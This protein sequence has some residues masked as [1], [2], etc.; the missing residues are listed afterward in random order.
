MRMEFRNSISLLICLVLCF[1]LCGCDALYRLLD[2]EGAQEKE[3]IGELIP[4]EKNLVVEEVQILLYLYGYNTGKIDGVLGLRTRSAIEKFQKDNGLEPSRSID[5]MTWG[6]LNVFKENKLIIKRQLNIRFIQTL[7]K[8][9][10]VDPGNIDG[11]MG[12]KTRAAITKFQEAH[13]L[14]VDGRIG[15]QT[16]SKLAEFIS[17]ESQIEQ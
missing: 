8:E 1:M 17:V 7:L 10:G 5:Q 13:G 16:L 12:V 14:K 2:K 3:L 11:K 6:K 4:F 15:Y 9:A